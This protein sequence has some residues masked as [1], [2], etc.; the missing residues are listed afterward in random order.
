MLPP[1]EAEPATVDVAGS[2][3]AGRARRVQDAP[4]RPSSALLR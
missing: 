4:S 3:S 1:T 2:D